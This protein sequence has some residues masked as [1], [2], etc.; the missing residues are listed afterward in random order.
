MSV[1][2]LFWL[3]IPAAE[4]RSVEGAVNEPPKVAVIR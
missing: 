2:Q 3:F 1:N 4:H